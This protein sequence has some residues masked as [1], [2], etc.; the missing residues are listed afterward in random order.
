V[1]GAGSYINPVVLF[2]EIAI[3]GLAEDRLLIDPNAVVISK[4][5]EEQER[6]RS[7]R[8]TIGST[9]SGT[10]A[11]VQ[12]R[13]SRI[14]GIRFARD[15]EQLRRFVCPVTP[16]LRDVL[17][18]NNRIIIEGTQGFGLSLLHSNCYPFVT[19]RDTS[20]AA[21][22][23]EAGLSPLD[24]DDIVMVLR[25]FPIR[26]GGNSGPLPRE[27]NWETITR[28]SGSQTFIIEHTSVTKSIRRVARFDPE[29]VR[30][31]IQVNKPTRIV[32]NHLDYVDSS[33]IARQGLTTKAS[34]FV[35][36]IENLISASIDFVGFG[37]DCL[38]RHYSSKVKEA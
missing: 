29:V 24:V 37:P 19:S 8:Q 10:G 6:E 31:A 28:E 21:F 5:E 1:I 26:V 34:G 27:I 20:A 32:L 11:A 33:C 38:I 9:L 14:E 13:I 7:L 23:S 3:T 25:S 2:E 35:N 30:D 22:V 15:D 16:F 36:E 12:G 18:T 4:N 17:N